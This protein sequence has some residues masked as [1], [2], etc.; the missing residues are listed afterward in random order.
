MDH[1]RQNT[2]EY[3]GV[4]HEG[5]I[6]GREMGPSADKGASEGPKVQDIDD[7]DNDNIIVNP[8]TGALHQL[9]E[10]M[11]PIRQRNLP[12]EEF[13][14]SFGKLRSSTYTDNTRQNV[15]VSSSHYVR[16][17]SWNAPG[18][19]IATGAAD[20][21]LRVWNPE[22]TL[23][24]NSTELKGH[25]GGVERVAFHPGN[26]TE[27]ASCSSD[28]SVR[29]WDVR[30]K[31]YIGSFNFRSK[32]QAGKDMGDPFTLAW[33]PDGTEM[34]IGTK[35]HDITFPTDSIPPLTE[36]FSLE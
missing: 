30:S 23:A 13:A 20:R 11:A 31:N 19:L 21:T 4:G 25:T 28:G 7:N 35:V 18:T 27:L 29:F 26:E 10:V 12:K 34:I 17:L 24:K 32:E 22:R 8:E 6:Y 33:K 3:I 15:P 14:K 2:S 36:V 16:T 9:P 5:E 1:K